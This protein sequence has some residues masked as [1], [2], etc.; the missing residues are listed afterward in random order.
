MS[1]GGLWITEPP[2]DIKTNGHCEK[3]QRSVSLSN[4]RKQT[5]FFSWRR[6]TDNESKRKTWMEKAMTAR[7]HESSQKVK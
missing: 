6:P 1:D 4:E 3:E 7:C 5:F 2:L